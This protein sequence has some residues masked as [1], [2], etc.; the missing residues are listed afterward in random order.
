MFLNLVGKNHRGN[1]DKRSLVLRELEIE[2]DMALPV[3]DVVGTFDPNHDV[4]E[5]EN[6][7]YAIKSEY[8][9]KLMAKYKEVIDHGSVIS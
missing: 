4:F 6:V 2:L 9:R 3:T 8:A 7:L 5:R 1:F